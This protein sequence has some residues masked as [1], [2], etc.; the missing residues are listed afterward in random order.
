MGYNPFVNDRE[1]WSGEFASEAMMEQSMM[2]GAARIQDEL[3]DVGK[4]DWLGRNPATETV[5]TFPT[6]Q[7]ARG[8]CTA[9]ASDHPGVTMLVYQPSHEVLAAVKT[10][11]VTPVDSADL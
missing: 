4:F 9:E 10:P 2:D 3:L 8:W 7:A 6:F 1:T 11:T 5:A